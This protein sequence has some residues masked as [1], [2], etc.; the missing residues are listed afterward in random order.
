[1][2]RAA[3]ATRAEAAAPAAVTGRL[4]LVSWDR[5]R[6][7]AALDTLA[8]HVTGHHA[9]FGF[10]LPLFLMLSVALAVSKPVAP[11]T[12]RFLRRRVDRIVMPWVFWALVLTVLRAFF[13]WTDGRDPVGWVEWPMLFYGPRVHLWFL[14]FVVVAGLVAHLIHRRV[15]E[16]D[17][18]R[19]AT[20]AMLVAALMLPV[21]TRFDLGWPAKQW[22]FSLPAIPLGY[23]LGRLM[24]SERSLP[25]LRI[26][27]SA[28]YAV[29][30]ALGLVALLLE[31]AEAHY[32]ARFLGG[33]GLLVAAT[34]LPDQKDPITGKLVPLMLGVYVL[35][36]AVNGVFIHPWLSAVGLADVAVLKAGLTFGATMGLVALLRLTPV[37]RFL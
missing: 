12:G 8:L 15:R 34:W 25:R 6:V 4:Y 35:H 29:F 24:A 5:L 32:T 13:A 14:P 30:V 16:E 23:A 1:M 19:V 7:I 31:P 36:P 33:L 11:I 3:V 10:G 26:K 2:S 9:L 22:L 37:R 27:L 28:V 17:T 21:V 18:G 20:F